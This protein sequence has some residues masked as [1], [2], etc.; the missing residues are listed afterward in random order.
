MDTITAFILGLIQGLT[1]FLP[2]SSSGHLE[3]GKAVFGVEPETSLTFT[4]VVHG[5]TVLSTI[6][7]FHKDIISLFK[8]SLKFKWN[9]ENRYLAKIALSMIPVVFVGLLFKEEVEGFFNGNIAFVGSM[10]IITAFMLGLTHFIKQ[11]N[12]K[13]P[14]SNAFIIGIAQA[15]A[16]LPGLSRSGATI[17]TG[18]LLKN[19]KEEVTRFSFLMVLV[20][21]IAANLMDIMSGDL[22]SGTTV[23]TTPLIIGF[24]AAFV[25]GW[26]ACRWMLKIVRNGKLIW[27]AV[28][29][30]IVGVI[31]IIVS[32]I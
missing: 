14:F 16:V 19:S 2:V 22:T 28:Y 32:S 29:C 23:G 8:G 20:P 7:V 6:V 11:G 4:V 15:F 1:E 10:L 30:L 31:S 24:I 17:S 13:I 25:S 9:A 3:L 27:F 12:K 5:A 18:L 21:I 26:F